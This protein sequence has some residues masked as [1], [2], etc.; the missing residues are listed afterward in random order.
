MTVNSLFGS[1]LV[2]ALLG[3]TPEA[4]AVYTLVHRSRRILLSHQ[5]DDAA[6][7]SATSSSARRC[8]ASTTST[9]ATATTTA[10]SLGRTCCS[11]PTRTRRAS[12]RPAASTT[13]A[14]SASA[15]CRAGAKSIAAERRTRKRGRRCSAGDREQHRVVDRVDR[16]VGAD[17]R[18]RVRLADAAG[19]L[20]LA[21]VSWV[22]ERSQRYR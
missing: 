20:D 4:G 2:Y 15:R 3:L 8:T 22:G 13:R 12:P 1:A 14:S 18:R 9:V 21:G 7:G 10:T 16:A 5:R 6:L 11:A 19:Q 17:R